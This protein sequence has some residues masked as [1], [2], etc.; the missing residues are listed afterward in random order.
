MSQ[1]IARAL[2][3][4]AAYIRKHG[5]CQH[6]MRA[7]DGSVCATGAV[8]QS[9]PNNWKIRYACLQALQA[10]IN[11]EKLPFWN[12]VAG[13]TK[14][15]VLALFATA[16]KVERRQRPKRAAKAIESRPARRRRPA[17]TTSTH[18]PL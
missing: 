4:A 13:R 16:A 3:E 7:E 5:W 9:E 10:C 6:R 2:D 11:N 17:W 18:T 12:D 14:Q 1:K 15:E 8:V